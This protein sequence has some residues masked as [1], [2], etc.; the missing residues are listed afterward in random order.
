M[1]SV[2][3]ARDVVMAQLADQIFSKGHR[4]LGSATNITF[5]P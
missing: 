5:T 1:N 4:F 2:D 3:D